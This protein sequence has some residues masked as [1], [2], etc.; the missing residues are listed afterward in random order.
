MKNLK[1]VFDMKKKIIIT[2]LAIIAA[3]VGLCVLIGII[4]IPYSFSSYNGLLKSQAMIQN[5]LMN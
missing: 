2:L 4:A 3:V 5:L 1:G